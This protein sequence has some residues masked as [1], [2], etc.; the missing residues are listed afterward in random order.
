MTMNNIKYDIAIIGAGPA[1][2]MAAILVAKNG[3]KVVLLEKNEKIGRKIL[4]TGNGRCNITNKYITEKNYRGAD[5]YFILD[6]LRQFNQEA[7]IEFFES[8]GLILKEEN[9]GRMF[10][11]TNQASSVVELLNHELKKQNVTVLTGFEVKNIEN[12]T[13]WLI[14]SADGKMIESNKL[15]M[16]TGGRAA[17]HLG[18][19]GDGLHWANKLGHSLSPIYPALVPIETVET[20]TK[21]VSGVKLEAN[22]SVEFEGKIISSKFGDL[23]F[24][25]FGLSGPAIMAQ[26]SMIAPLLEKNKVKLII[27]IFPELLKE[28]LDK[29]LALILANSG[30]KTVKNSLLGVAPASILPIILRDASIDTNKKSAEISKAERIRIVDA[31]KKMTLLVKELRPFREAQVTSGGVNL[32]EV[33]AKTLESKIVPNLYFAGEILDVDGDSGGFNLQWAWS[34]GYVAGSSAAS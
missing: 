9:N 30:A 14:G 20:W 28:E 4:A 16:A 8:L 3:K 21:E 22:V 19:S 1:G 23:L 12:N 33:N 31:M 25:H 15:I 17:H 7:T 34:S 11:R 13:H 18:S 27:D 32:V 5:K 10:P 6:V 24:T 29:K 26:S 2:I